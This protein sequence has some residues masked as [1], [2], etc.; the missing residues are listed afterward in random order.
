MQRIEALVPALKKARIAEARKNNQ[1]AREGGVDTTA[2]KGTK[3]G[4]PERLEVLKGIRK[5]NAPAPKQLELTLEARK[6]STTPTQLELPLPDPGT[7]V[8][9]QP[10]PIESVPEPQTLPSKSAVT[11]PIPQST[12]PSEPIS[13]KGA[14]GTATTGEPG[15]G[16]TLKSLGANIVVG[17]AYSMSFERRQAKIAEV[18]GKKLGDITQMEMMGMWQNGYM[19]VKDPS[20]PRGVRWEVNYQTRIPQALVDMLMGMHLTPLLNQPPQGTRQFD[21]IG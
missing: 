13:A 2:V 3:Y 17:I 8:D 4:Q 11:E 16:V 1:F 12:V 9:S 5:T 14:G 20:D 7:P 19:P 15:I 10:H 21:Q 18:Q 6:T